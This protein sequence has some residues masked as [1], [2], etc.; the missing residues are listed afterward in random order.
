VR[1]KKEIIGLNR[2]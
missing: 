1:Q 2:R